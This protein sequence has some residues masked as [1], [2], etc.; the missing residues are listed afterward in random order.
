MLLSITLTGYAQKNIMDEVIWVVGDEIILKSDVEFQRLRAELEGTKID[1]DPYAVIPEQLAVNKLFLHQ[2]P[3]DSIEV[4]DADVLDEAN[5][6]VDYMI[7]MAGSQEKLEEYRGMSIKKIK[8]ELI[9]YLVE[10]EK[11]NQEKKKIIGAKKISPAEVRRYFKTMPKDSLPLIPE[12]VEVQ[13]L[14]QIPDV[15]RQEVDRIKEELQDYAKRVNSGESSFAALARLYSQDETSARQ[16]GELGYMGRGQLVPEFA[17]VAFSLTDKKTVSKIVKSEYGYHI[18]QLIDRK[19]DKV[20]V[21]HIL[22]RPSVDRIAIDKCMLRLDSISDDI[23][24]GKFSFEEAVAALSDDKDTKNN[25]GI[26]VFKDPQTYTQT[27]RFTMD[28]LNQ[29]VAKVVSIMHVGEISKPFKMV[30]RTGQE[31]CAIVKLK[32]RIER[33][34]ADITEDFQ[35]LSDIV[36]AKKNEDAL[37]NWIKEKQKTTYVSI[38]DGWRNKKF[39]YPGW[40]K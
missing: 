32:N 26:M 5:A 27:S 21:R 11:I 38:K 14:T 1:G 18:M 35:T 23:R 28:N 29:D 17:N 20:N 9:K 6:R 34:R 40:I 30:D 15:S 4:S 12:T 37:D 39:H 16:G 22:L 33:H 7:Q 13:I 10:A 2:A 24:N 31:V 19:G 36:S 25:N 8:Q 3:I